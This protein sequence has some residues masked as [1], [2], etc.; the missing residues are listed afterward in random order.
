MLYDSST[1]EWIREGTSS[2]N[3]TGGLDD[4]PLYDGELEC[5]RMSGG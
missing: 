2:M 5:L 1:R 3:I 4:S